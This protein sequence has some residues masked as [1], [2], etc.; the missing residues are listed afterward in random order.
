MGFSPRVFSSFPAFA[1]VP[2]ATAALA[3]GLADLQAGRTA[4]AAA[5]TPAQGHA[6]AGLFETSANCLAC[7]NSLTTSTG[8][9]ISIGSEWRSSMMANAA[10]DP[11]WQAAVRRETLDHPMHAADIEDEC[12]ICHMPMA[13]TQA[14]AGGGVGQIFAHL[15]VVERTA[16]DDLI[17]HDGVSCTVCHQIT[18][19]NLGSPE[20]FTGGFVIDTTQVTERSIFG[21]FE[22][23]TG[24][25][26]VMRSATG[27]QP[28]EATHIQQS[29]LCATC[30]TLITTSFGPNGEVT[31]ELPE[32]VMYLEWRHS[33]YREKASCQSCHMPVVTEDTPISSVLGEPRA[34]FS[35]HSFVG[36]NFFMLGMLNRYRTELGVTAL[37]LEM[38]AAVRRT[39]RNLQ[40][41]TAAVRVERAAVTDGQLKIDV[42]VENV[43]GH[44]LPTAYPSR[45]AWL[46]L[47]VQDRNG[48]TVFESGRIEPTGAIRGN[49]NDASAVRF[50]PHYAEIR[51]ADEVQIYEA[52]MGDPR[53][54]PTTGLLTATAYLK[55]NRLLPA[56]FDKATAERDIRV[57]GGALTDADFAGGG[58]RVR[59][60]VDVAA[61]D[62]P[63]RVDVELRFQPIGYRWAENLKPFEAP[64]PQRFVRY[65]ESM[66]AASSERLA[67]AT[68]TV[69][70]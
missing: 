69:G 14:H 57:L 45:R 1:L 38:D 27:F 4:S 34:G 62:G 10:R 64:E 47:T 9:D 25:T 15:P 59:Y 16:P 46:H 12:S 65:Y 19:Q 2:A 5:P 49:D 21:P 3:L 31:G 42:A 29:E 66:S 11:Y 68:A 6:T 44:K 58:D 52:I 51:Q 30:H 63:F 39:V 18:D 54:T 20:S 56:G 8:E 53:G 17:A 48:R 50:E 70:N 36:G 22:V 33:D 35:R 37:P 13:R 32:Q 43:T 41:A 24:L 26:A 28:T 7:H 40:T 67:A 61:G 55:D 60:L 23:D